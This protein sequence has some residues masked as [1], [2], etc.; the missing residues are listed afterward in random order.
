V[1]TVDVLQQAQILRLRKGRGRDGLPLHVDVLPLAGAAGTAGR[2]A[3]R[4]VGRGA[5]GNGGGN[6]NDGLLGGG[7]GGYCRMLLLLGLILLAQIHL[8]F[9]YILCGVLHSGAVEEIL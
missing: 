8:G 2:A 6:V 4:V 7:G 3:V 1:L 9:V 5:G